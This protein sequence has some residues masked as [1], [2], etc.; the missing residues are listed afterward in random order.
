MVDLYTEWY[1]YFALIR[2]QL[3]ALDEK[4]AIKRGRSIIE[5]GLSISILV[6]AG[7]ENVVHAR[8]G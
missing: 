1:K 3:D 5:S 6:I 4:I 8:K 7:K 2:E